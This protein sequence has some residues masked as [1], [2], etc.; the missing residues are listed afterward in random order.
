M[1]A[2]LNDTMKWYGITSQSNIYFNKSD[3]SPMR[4]ASPGLH[5]GNPPKTMGWIKVNKLKNPMKGRN[6]VMEVVDFPSILES[7]QYKRELFT[8]VN[9]GR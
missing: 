6:I 4:A 8:G 5:L 3:I 1:V 7:T 9:L 2:Y